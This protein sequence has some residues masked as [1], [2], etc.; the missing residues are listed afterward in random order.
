MYQLASNGGSLMQNGGTRVLQEA[1]FSAISP[2]LLAHVELY[3]MHI[4][5]VRSYKNVLLKIIKTSVDNKCKI[6][7]QQI[8]LCYRQHHCWFR[9]SW[10]ERQTA[11]CK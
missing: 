1:L 11:Q 2:H 7:D 10:I 9:E 4:E 5:L 8:L 3:G 6:V